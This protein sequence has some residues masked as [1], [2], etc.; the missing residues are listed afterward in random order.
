[1]D[2][3]RIKLTAE[4]IYK[5][6]FKVDTK[7][8]RIKEVDSFLDEIIKD[9]QEFSR[10]IREKDKEKMELMK[11]IMILKEENRN[12]KVQV[13]LSSDDNVLPRETSNLDL[14]KR[15]SELEKIVYGKEEK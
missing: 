13:E 6:E 10:I 9:Y 3:S 7:G 11:E 4:E 5:Q 14:M 8:Y 1:M 2:Q 12:L 15:L